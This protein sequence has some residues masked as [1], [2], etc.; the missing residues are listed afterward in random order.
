MELIPKIFHEVEVNSW[1]E[2]ACSPSDPGP[3][4]SGILINGPEKVIL[5]NSGSDAIIPVCGYYQLD[6][7]DIYDADPL[8]INLKLPGSDDFVIG[9]IVDNDPSPDEPEPF[10][11]EVNREDLADLGTDGYFNPNILDFVNIILIPGRYELFVDFGGHQSNVIA[12]E[13]LFNK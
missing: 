9:F 4:W 2:N 5:S 10:D 1:E 13:I 7:I 12:F 8:R 3:E 6:L 11:T